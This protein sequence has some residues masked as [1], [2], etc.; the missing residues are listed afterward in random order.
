MANKL[1]ELFKINNVDQ[2]NCIYK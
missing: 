2:I 1:P